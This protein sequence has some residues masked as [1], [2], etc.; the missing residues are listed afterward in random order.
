MEF[1]TG[2]GKLDSNVWVSTELYFTF[3]NSAVTN[4]TISSLYPG[5]Q[6]PRKKRNSPSCLVLGCFGNF[7]NRVRDVRLLLD[8]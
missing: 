4:K 6:K 3:Q 2:K 5:K 8:P 7:L 1:Y